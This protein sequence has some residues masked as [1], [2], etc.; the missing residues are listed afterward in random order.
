MFETVDIGT[1]HVGVVL[2][3]VAGKIQTK[4]AAHA[5][6]RKFNAMRFSRVGNT[7]G[8]ALGQGSQVFIE[9][10][11]LNDFQ[12]FQTGRNRNRIAGQCTCLIHAAQRGNI[13]HNVFTAA[14]RRQRHTAAD[15]FAHG[16][17]IRFDAVQRLR[18]AQ[19]HTEAGHHFVVNQHGTVFFS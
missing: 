7:V 6:R 14:K 3:R 16:G 1:R 17:Q 10:F 5:V 2:R 8:E 19:R 13:F 18:T 12:R 15:H 9:A 11:T 4:H